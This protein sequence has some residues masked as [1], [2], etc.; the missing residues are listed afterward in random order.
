[1]LNIAYTI[2]QNTF[3]LVQSDILMGNTKEY[4][5]NGDSVV[6][7]GKTVEADNNNSISLIIP[8]EFAKE[9]GIENS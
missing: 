2:L 9:L 5:K 1:M 7:I 3:N 8:K 4:D 6:P